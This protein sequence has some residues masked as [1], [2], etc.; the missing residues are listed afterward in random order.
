[1]MKL[2]VASG[3]DFDAADFVVVFHGRKLSVIKNRSAAPDNITTMPDSAFA[4]I[5][6]R[7]EAGYEAR[8]LKFL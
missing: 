5:P 1:M 2:T 4:F 3:K 6:K 8:E 7:D